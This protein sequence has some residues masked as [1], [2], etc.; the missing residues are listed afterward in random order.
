MPVNGLRKY[1]GIGTRGTL[2]ELAIEIRHAVQDDLQQLAIWNR[3]TDR[4]VEPALRSQ[5]T[6]DVAVLL[7]LLKGFPCGHLLCALSTRAQEQIGTIWHVAVWEPLQGFGIGTRLML[8]A[9]EEIVQRGLGWSQLGVEK[10]NTGARRLYE[11]LGYVRFGD[12]DQVWPEPTPDGGLAPVA[13][14]CWLMRKD[15]RGTMPRGPQGCPR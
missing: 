9:E 8:A 1:E 3:A 12:E 4:V 11:R 2:V 14:P 10:V 6:G 13:H 7:A 15:L 5:E